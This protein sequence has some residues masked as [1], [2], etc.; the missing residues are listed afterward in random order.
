MTNLNSIKNQLIDELWLPTASNGGGQLFPRRKNKGMKLLTLTNHDNLNEIKRIIENRLSQTPLTVAW[1]HD[2]LKRIR[3]ESEGIAKFILGPSRF[4]ESIVTPSQNLKD[5]FPF[6]IVNL[7]FSSQEPEFENERIEK[8]LLGLENTIKLQKE[9]K[10]GK[11]GFVLLYTTLLNSKEISCDRLIENSNSIVTQG[12]SGN[13]Y[14]NDYPNNTAN[15]S[16]KID[17]IE[18]IIN[19]LASKYGH[20]IGMDNKEIQFNGNSYI[21]SLAGIIKYR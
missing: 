15:H 8:E 2:Y 16:D 14:F 11:K 17:I 3:L 13:L 10:N 1:N 7:D 5:F 12:W 4:E 21:F 6:D 18:S 20:E 9:T 19:Q